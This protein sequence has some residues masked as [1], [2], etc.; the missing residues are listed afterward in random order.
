MK[1]SILIFAAL[2]IA[3]TV[4]T[5]SSCQKNDNGNTSTLQLRLTDGPGDFEEVNVDIRDVKVK[6]N[7]D[8]LAN[9]GWI[10]LNVNAGVY[11]LLRLQNGID[12]VL[13]TGNNIP[14]NAILREI[15]I[16]LG[17]NNSVKVNGQVHPLVLNSGDHPKLK[18]KVSKKLQATFETVVI[19]FDAG[20]SIKQEGNGTYRLIPVIK[21]KP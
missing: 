11:D 3:V 7:D 16:Y 10:D 13:A 18:I 4:F 17:Q 21:I 19:D 14:Q 8:T 2:F 15:R 12:T 9:D 1:K 5:I 20:L 6:F